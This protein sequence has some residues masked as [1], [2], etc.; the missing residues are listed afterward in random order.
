MKRHH[1]NKAFEILQ[2]DDYLSCK[3][4]SKQIKGGGSWKEGH[5]FK[6][7]NKHADKRWLCKR[8]KEK[9]IKR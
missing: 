1:D 2:D 5:G 4:N 6:K 8:L 3:I 9:M 7:G